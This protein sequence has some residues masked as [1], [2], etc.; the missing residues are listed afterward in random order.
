MHPFTAALRSRDPQ[1]MTTMLA[2]DVAY[3]SPVMN[4]P[5][6]GTGVVEILEI[7]C[8]VLTS[9]E[10]LQEHANDQTLVLTGAVTVG[11][12]TGNA[13]WI[14]HFDSAGDIREIM[15][16]VRP[17]DVTVRTL[18]GFGA[19]MGARRSRSKHLLAAMSK[20]AMLLTAAAVDHVAPLLAPTSTKSR[21]VSD[22]PS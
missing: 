1:A 4:R 11:D 2:A 14:I 21:R 16:H 6:T 18:N 10:D 5:I 8:Q 12:R 7:L 13:C 3:H 19:G 15:W 20:P 22:D 9:V 17:F